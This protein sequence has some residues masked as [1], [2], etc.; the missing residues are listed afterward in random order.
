MLQ[1]TPQTRIVVCVEPIDFR[2]GIDGLAQCCKAAPGEDPFRGTVFV[3]R[4]RRSTAVKLLAY[5]TASE[6]ASLQPVLA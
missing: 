2:K 1:V 5:V 3:F 4:N 6:S